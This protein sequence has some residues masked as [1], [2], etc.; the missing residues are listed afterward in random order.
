VRWHA[1]GSH[2]SEKLQSADTALCPEPTPAA[3]VPGLTAPSKRQDTTAETLGLV[4]GSTFACGV[5]RIRRMEPT[6]KITWLGSCG[7]TWL[8]MIKCFRNP[9]LVPFMRVLCLPN[10]CRHG[11]RGA[12]RADVW[13]A[14][15]ALDVMSLFF[16]FTNRQRDFVTA[17][18]HPLACFPAG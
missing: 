17:A 14:A 16:P 18:R 9:S 10:L 2:A 15:S 4:Q 3:V 8:E 1:A 6:P 11:S 12:S 5:E 13:G 7:W